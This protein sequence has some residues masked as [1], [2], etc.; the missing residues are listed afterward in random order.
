MAMKC[1]HRHRPVGARST[2]VSRVDLVTQMAP[3]DIADGNAV[4]R[5]GETNAETLLPD[6]FVGV[7]SGRSPRQLGWR[8]RSSDVRSL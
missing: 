8:S 4:P 2:R 1:S 5:N 3:F 6:D 7:L